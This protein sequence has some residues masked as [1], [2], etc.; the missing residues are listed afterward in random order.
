MTTLDP[1]TE[2][3]VRALDSFAADKSPGKSRTALLQAAAHMRKLATENAR[4]K[5]E[6]QLFTFG[7]DDV[8]AKVKERLDKRES[9]LTTELSTTRG[10]LAA[11]RTLRASFGGH[12][13]TLAEAYD[14]APGGAFEPAEVV[15]AAI[16]AKAELERLRGTMTSEE[17]RERIV[18]V[19]L[20]KQSFS[21]T[22]DAI[23]STIG[24]KP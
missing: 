10:S 7:V 17:T 14:M 19:L 6:A 4:L 18:R 21:E 12:L 15:R 22:V 2:R 5:A 23:I 24:N 3:H 16:A 8:A 9:K 11:E 1:E 13:Q 20:R